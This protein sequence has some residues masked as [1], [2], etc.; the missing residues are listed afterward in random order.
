MTLAYFE[1]LRPFDLGRRLYFL[2]ASSSIVM[3]DVFFFAAPDDSCNVSY[4]LRRLLSGTLVEVSGTIPF[5][6]CASWVMQSTG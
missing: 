3:L 6:S 2:I 1:I 4:E 5:V